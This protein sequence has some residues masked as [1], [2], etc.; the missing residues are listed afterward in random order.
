MIIGWTSSALTGTMHCPQKRAM[1]H[2]TVARPVNGGRG[3]VMVV[4]NKFCSLHGLP[5][6]DMFLNMYLFTEFHACLSVWTGLW[7]SWMVWLH[8]STIRHLA[9]AGGTG[10]TRVISGCHNFSWI[11]YGCHKWSSGLHIA[12]TYVSHNWSQTIHGHCIWSPIEIR[13]AI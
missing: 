9:A 5:H 1:L 6:V 2:C 12:A 7:L 8:I 13:L 3:P 11:G 10:T 4:I